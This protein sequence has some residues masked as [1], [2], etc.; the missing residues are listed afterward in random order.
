MSQV[1][2][3]RFLNGIKLKTTND[4][5]KNILGSKALSSKKKFELWPSIKYKVQSKIATLW[6]KKF[7]VLSTV[8]ATVWS[9]KMLF[10]YTSINICS[11][12]YIAH[13][14]IMCQLHRKT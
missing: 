13:L 1:F 5:A 2:Q 9:G 12:V 7:V 14:C 10:Y 8:H 3:G 11:V 4:S 6:N